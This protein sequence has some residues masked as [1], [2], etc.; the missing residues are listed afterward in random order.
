MCSAVDGLAGELVGGLEVQASRNHTLLA[1]KTERTEQ[2]AN[3]LR[4]PHPPGHQARRNPSAKNTIAMDLELT[5]LIKNF[6][7]IQRQLLELIQKN[8]PLIDREAFHDLPKRGFLRL[9]GSEWRYKR[10]GKGLSFVQAETGVEVDT[11]DL[12]EHPEAFDAW[13]ILLYCESLK[14]VH[15]SHQGAIHE[16][17][18]SELDRLFKELTL[19]GELLPLGVYGEHFLL[20]GS[21][22]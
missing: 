2:V 14:L 4:C 10:H 15:I 21:G 12:I 1:Q 11:H 13:R 19:N 17:S 7:A 3:A 18:A 9:N 5:S 22:R 6:V 8:Q 20:K 16:I